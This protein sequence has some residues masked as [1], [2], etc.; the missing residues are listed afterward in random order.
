M[1]LP[2]LVVFFEGSVSESERFGIA[3]NLTS[4]KMATLELFDIQET[5]G[6]MLIGTFVMLVIYGITMLQTYLY[7]TSF[8][9]DDGPTKA[10]VASIWIL[11]TTHAVLAGHCMHYYLIAG[12]VDHTILANGNWSLFLSLATNLIE[13]FIVQAFFTRRIFL[14]CSPQR[15]WWVAGVI[16]VFVVAHF[17]FGIET[18]VDL[19]ATKEFIRLKKLSFS[20]VI[21][22]GV[23]T[24]ISDILI[25]IALCVLLHNNRSD[26]GD[27][28]SII[29]KLIVYAINRCILT[30]AV[31]IAETVVFSALPNT[32]YSFAMD[33]VIGKLYANSLLAVL[34]SRAVLRVPSRADLS[35]TELST[36]FHVASAVTNHHTSLFQ[37]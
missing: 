37:V 28:N 29:N 26:F 9:K 14:L 8:P 7:F 35:S 15:R 19:F 24:I 11:D 16:T 13:A 18:V 5:F 12:F 2:L 22:F 30:S 20:S 33:F 10:L 23:T 34:N 21:P 3:L 17:V 31:A 27:T 36:R 1:L 6:A 32:L 4:Q 25:A